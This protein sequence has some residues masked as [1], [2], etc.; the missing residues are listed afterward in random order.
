MRVKPSPVAVEAFRI[1]APAE[2]RMAVA[3]GRLALGEAVLQRLTHDA[4]VKK[5]QCTAPI[6]INFGSRLPQRRRLAL[7]SP[8]NCL[9]RT[10]DGT[11]PTDTPLRI[12][13]TFDIDWAPDWCVERCVS[14][15]DRFGV[16]ATFFATHASEFLEEIKRRA[17]MF[18]VGLHPNFHPGSSHG[19]GTAEVIEHCRGFAGTARSMR[20][21]GLMQWSNLYALIANDFNLSEESRCDALVMATSDDKVAWLPAQ[22]GIYKDHFPFAK[23]RLH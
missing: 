4:I 20:T 12:A 18:E 3:A 14:I 5:L 15:L 10:A 1:N 13:I 17:D 11:M 9:Q 23:Q 21:H 6:A 22:I 2:L 19:S 7:L 16:K 8:G